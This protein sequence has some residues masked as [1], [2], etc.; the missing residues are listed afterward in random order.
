MFMEEDVYCQACPLKI[1]P[2]HTDDDVQKHSGGINQCIPGV[3]NN[4]PGTFIAA[5][6]VNVRR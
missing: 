6:F 5:P 4:L 3:V 2:V 1:E